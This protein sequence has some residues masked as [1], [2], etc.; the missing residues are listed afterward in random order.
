MSFGFVK[1]LKFFWKFLSI[2]TLILIL[3]QSPKSQGIGGSSIEVQFTQSVGGS[4]TL[5]LATWISILAFVGL[6]AYLS[7]ASN[8]Y[9][10]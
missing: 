10:L 3:L 5:I 7:L 9:Y 6:T 2:S 8:S 1:I 4:K